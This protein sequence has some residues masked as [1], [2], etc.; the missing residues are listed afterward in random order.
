MIWR[1]TSKKYGFIAKL[2]HWGMALIVMGLVLLG[3]YMEPLDFSPFKLSLYDWHKSFGTLVLFLVAARFLWRFTGKMPEAID[4]HKGWEKFSAHIAHYIL[5][6][7]MLLLPLTGWLMSSA[8]DFSHSFFGLFEM[9]DLVSK[10]R[11][12]FRFMRQA[13]EVLVYALLV[14]LVLHIAGAV[15]HHVMDKDI[16]F[17]RMLPFSDASQVMAST[18]ILLVFLFYVGTAFLIYQAGKTELHHHQVERATG[19]L[20]QEI[21]Q[22][23]NR[24]NRMTPVEEANMA[25][26]D[27]IPEESSLSF[28]VDVYDQAFEASFTTFSGEVFFSPDQLEKSRVAITIPMAGVKSGSPERDGF[29][30]MEPW[31]NAES[32]PESNFVADVFKKTEENQYVAHGK[33]TLRGVTMPLSLPFSLYVTPQENGPDKA[34]MAAEVIINRLDYGVGQ[35]EWGN[36]DTVGNAVKVRVDI[37]ARKVERP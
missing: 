1:N 12:T 17:K 26:W 21:L 14:V 23:E 15:K 28:Y 10:D 7:L 24:K 33:L 6:L 20:E 25:R 35:G 30:V 9:P 27:I 37:V 3:V 13:H 11:E 32:F 4:T 16:T 34:F 5:Y 18:T 19:E 36:T 2:F 31:F 29:M 22:D 8:G